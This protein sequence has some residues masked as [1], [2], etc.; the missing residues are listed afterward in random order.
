MRVGTSAATAAPAL[1]CHWSDGEHRHNLIQVQVR[2]KAQ[3]QKG[4]WTSFQPIP[5]AGRADFARHFGFGLPALRHILAAF[6]LVLALLMP[7]QGQAQMLAPTA[8]E[9]LTATEA[10]TATVEP[11]VGRAALRGL[12]LK[13]L[14]AGKKVAIYYAGTGNMYDTGILIAIS[15]VG[16]YAIYIGNEYFWD[17][18]APAAAAPSDGGFDAAESAWRN[19]LKYLTLK[20]AGMAFNWAMLYAYTGSLTT[21]AVVGS[22]NS[23][24][25]PITFYLNNMGWDW[26]E[27]S[28]RS[29][30]GTAATGQTGG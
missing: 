17:K 25:G 15:T 19:T 12:T 1:K 30:V 9:P 16:T 5:T 22:A 10:P 27:W 6:I 13:A 21:M 28:T 20:P 18:N 29:P 11:S 26:Y 3:R 23:L 4:T 7:F 8:T 2:V 14:S 24:T